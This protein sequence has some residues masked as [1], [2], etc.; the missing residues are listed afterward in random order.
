M[1]MVFMNLQQPLICYLDIG[2]IGTLVRMT[3]EGTETGYVNI[4]Y[5]PLNSLKTV[6]LPFP[7]FKDHIHS[8]KPDKRHIPGVQQEIMFIHTGESDSLVTNVLYNEYQKTIDELRAQNRSLQM[9]A[10]SAKQ[11]ARQA[12]SSAEEYVTRARNLTQATGKNRHPLSPNFEDE[13]EYEF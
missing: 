8:V 13:Q 11:T 3:S 12:A 1:N 10:S 7:V 5:K 6:K 4:E 9:E 2:L